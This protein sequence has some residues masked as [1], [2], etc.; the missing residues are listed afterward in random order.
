MPDRKG[1]IKMSMWRET[2]GGVTLETMHA[3]PFPAWHLDT[4]KAFKQL[5]LKVLAT[6]Q[7]QL[8]FMCVGDERE[9]G[10]GK[11]TTAIPIRVIFY[12]LVFKD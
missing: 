6:S 3:P 12:V 5:P 8:L 9:A 7:R 11:I 1:T 10:W 4:T 2:R